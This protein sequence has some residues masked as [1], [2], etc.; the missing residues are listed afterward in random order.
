MLADDAVPSKKATHPKKIKPSSTADQS[1]PTAD[2][3]PE[4]PPSPAAEGSSPTTDE[5]PQKQP[6]PAAYA[7]LSPSRRKKKTKHV[8]YIAY[9]ETPNGRDGK[10]AQAYRIHWRRKER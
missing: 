1:S 3:Y 5:S 10:L 2:K 7:G 9:E 6:S 8:E 4:N